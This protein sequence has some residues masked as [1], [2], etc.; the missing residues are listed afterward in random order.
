MKRMLCGLVWGPLSG[1][2]E[3]EKPLPAARAGLW[4]K[5]PTS[6]V[7]RLGGPCLHEGGGHQSGGQGPSAPLSAWGLPEGKRGALGWG[8]TWWT[9]VLNLLPVFVTLTLVSQ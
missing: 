6:G 5:A 1:M 9:L 2:R 3:L 8:R 7:G 4:G